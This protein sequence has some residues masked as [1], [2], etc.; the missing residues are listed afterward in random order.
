LTKKLGADMKN[1]QYGQNAYHHVLIKHP[2]SNAVNEANRKK[3]EVG[4]LPRGGNSS[5]PGMTTNNDN[6]NA[7]A[8]FRIVTDL[9]DWDKTLFTNA[10]GQSGDVESIFY[11]NLF[12]LWATD[13]HFPVYYSREKIEKVAKE[14][15]FLQP[16]R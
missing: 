3:L 7:G 10:P 12:E 4:P 6:Q 2:M 11:K 15:W 13:Q 16:S 1:W 14:R 5:S 8:T 9:A